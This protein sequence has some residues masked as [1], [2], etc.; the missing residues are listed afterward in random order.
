M[1]TEATK[2]K[3]SAF[4][5]GKTIRVLRKE[6]HPEVHL[7]ELA[8]RTGCSKS[9]LSSI[10]HGTSNASFDMLE[11]I[12]GALRVDMKAFV[13]RYSDL[14][15]KGATEVPAESADAA[16]KEGSPAP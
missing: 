7:E 13:S 14:R 10:E 5:V 11:R 15:A 3:T 9:H 16:E 1:S 12:A 8:K 4:W 6:A 2:T